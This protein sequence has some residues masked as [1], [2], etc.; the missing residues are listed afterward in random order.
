MLSFELLK[1]HEGPRLF[2]APDTL[3]GFHEILHDVNERSP[4]ILDKEGVFL[5]LA[6]DVRK[7]YEGARI[8]RKPARDEVN[9]GPLFGVDMLWPVLLLQCRMLRASLGFIDSTKHH[10]AYA[11]AL[12][13]VVEDALRA[14][15]GADSETIHAEYLRVIPEHPGVYDDMTDRIE[16][17]A[18]WSKRERRARLANLL[19]TLDPMYAFLYKMRAEHGE[20]GLLSPEEVGIAS[21][22]DE[23]VSARGH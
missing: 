5:A 7:A 2:G 21:E 9:A 12:E 18:G 8:K 16:L 13:A 3:R 23:P 4:I 20:G 17:Y 22:D 15:F 6:Y 14:D 1:D 19:E 11:Y 10:Q